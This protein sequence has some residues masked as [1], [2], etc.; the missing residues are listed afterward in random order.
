MKLNTFTEIMKL[1]KRKALLYIELKKLDYEIAYIKRHD[2]CP[3]I[4]VGS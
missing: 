1:E 2:E 4:V 3:P